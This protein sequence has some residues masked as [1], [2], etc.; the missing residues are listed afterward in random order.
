MNARIL[1]IEFDALRSEALEQALVDTGYSIAGKLSSDSNLLRT[2]DDLDPDL[3]VINVAK[4][5]DGL[6]ENIKQLNDLNPK[7]IVIFADKGDSEIISAA[8]TA[9]VSAFIVDGL[10]ARRIQPVITVALERF[11][12]TQSLKD[13]LKKVK[14]TLAER[15]LIEKAKGIVMKQRNVNEESAFQM[16]RKTAMEN[17][18]KL[19]EIAESIISVSDL[20]ES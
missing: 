14:I 6:M 2:V 1:L 18:K 10:T 3:I 8:V 15:K 4:A 5:H 20:L 9:G 13:E 11:K 17:N 7:P 16:L 12:Q 19:I